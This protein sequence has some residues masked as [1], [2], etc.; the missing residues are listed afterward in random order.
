[1]HAHFKLVLTLNLRVSCRK[2][3][4]QVT[5]KTK[6]FCVA[7]YECSHSMEE[8]SPYTRVQSAEDVKK[9]LKISEK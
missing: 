8:K 3:L 1:M 6:T 5:L 2:V 4:L 9:L 7:F